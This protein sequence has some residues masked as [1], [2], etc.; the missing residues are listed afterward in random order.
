MR[1]ARILVLALVAAVVASG[2]V[3][4]HDGAK[5]AEAHPLGNFTINRLAR[6][7]L[8]GSGE[9]SLRYVVDMAEIPA[10]QEIRKVDLD[11]DGAVT[12]AESDAYVQTLM[13]A[14]ARRF[15]L[16]VSGKRVDLRPLSGQASLVPGQGGL[17][18]LRIVVDFTAS[19]PGEWQ[20]G[21]IAQFRDANFAD[22]LGWR[23]VVVLAGE[24]VALTESSA[25]PSD[26][27]AELTSYPEGRLKSPPQQSEA[28][29]RLQAG[30]TS[31]PESIS[32]PAA[33][34]KAAPGKTLGRFASL[35]SREK[36]TPAFILLSLLAA[37]AW[38]AAHALGPGHG[39][40]IVAAYL[41]GSR[42]TAKHALVLGLTVTAVHTA[43]VITLGLVTLSAT[44]F[45][46]TESLYFWLSVCSGLMV[47]AMGLGLLFARLRAFLRLRNDAGHARH[48]HDHQH[49]HHGLASDHDHGDEHRRDHAHIPTAPGWRGLI[50]L[51]VSGGLLP[52]PTALVVMLGAIALDRVVYG[53]VLVLAFS[54]GLA[55]VLTGIGLLLVYAG[56]VLREPGRRFNL[57]RP[58][59][60]RQ[61]MLMLPVLSALGIILAGLLLTTA[62]LS[63]TL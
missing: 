6:L 50:A 39:K 38:G 45:V 57:L 54:V 4:I 2:L 11:H 40:T 21:A 37:A 14:L 32:P 35:V 29:F 26:E 61:A 30:A 3:S 49:H 43:G 44:R 24:G 27:T 18:T 36:L 52:C 46:S 55:G 13:P 51:G 8:H 7:Q 53:L 5:T 42:G 1:A 15:E 19:L 41:V 28:R 25:S 12:S 22:R 34:A 23:E 60:A 17:S 62:A 63:A 31:W 16:K 58:G 56:R 33:T 48:P 10:F 47:V 20:S 9:V 59:L